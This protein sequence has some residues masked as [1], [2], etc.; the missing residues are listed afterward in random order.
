MSGLVR[1]FGGVTPTLAEGAFL[2]ETAAVIGD[3]ALGPG[4]SI[5]YGS[6]LRGDVAP[7]RVGA[8][9]N[10]Q[11]LSM[12]HGTTVVTNEQPRPDSRNRVLLPDVCGQFKVSR[13]DTFSLL[14]EMGTK[15]DLARD[16]R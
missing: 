1:A 2:A 12:V 6:V 4:S 10:I 8:R 11:D 15:F 14:R 13:K 5:W 9:S 16:N 3:V 7:I